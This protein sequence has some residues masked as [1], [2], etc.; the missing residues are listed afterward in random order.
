MGLTSNYGT[1][2]NNGNLLTV[3]YSGGGLSYTQT[4]DYDALN[5]LTTS[6]ESGAS[7]L[8]TNSYDRYGN[9]SI[10][11]GG[12]SFSASNNRITN[13]GYVYDAAGN[14]TNDGV[15]SYAFDAEN[16]V[17]TVN[18]E[19]DVY[20]YD[21]DGNRV[22]KNFTYGEK[23]RMVYS[24]QL[25]AE[26][27][28]STGS[29]K[30]EY[31][32]GAKGLI[33]TIEPSAGTRYT[34]SDHLGSPRV[35]SNSSAGVV[36]RHDYKPFGEELGAGEGGRT[37]AMGYDAAD[38]LRQKF[39][40]KERDN[41]TGL[42]YLLA[43]YYSSTQGRFTSADSFGGFM[44]NPQTLNRYAYVQN[45][46]L[47]FIDPTG[48]MAERWRI[49][50]LDYLFGPRVSEPMVGQDPKKKPLPPETQPGQDIGSKTA[51]EGGSPFGVIANLNIVSGQDLTPIET[52]NGGPTP[53]IQVRPTEVPVN[54][55]PSSAGYMDINVSW[56]YL[57][58]GPSVGVMFGNNGGISPYLGGG[59]MNP[60]PSANVS[61]SPDSISGGFNSEVQIGYGPATSW[62]WDETGTLFRSYGIGRGVSV[63]GYYVFNAPVPPR[64]RGRHWEHPNSATNSNSLRRDQRSRRNCACNAP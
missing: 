44:S 3:G 35:V 13:A 27:D 64:S 41:E 25:I 19:T 38:G 9:R 42:D 10:V 8:Q 60:G 36:S 37:T 22:R 58:V 40:S 57:I 1:I 47:N 29:L 21:G 7:W 5:R 45:D 55:P 14:L 32:Y 54:D 62:G 23:V 52:S 30:K 61:F 49:N 12:L 31:V 26:Y 53:S 2:N 63:T 39:T 15:H 11:G 33:A 6:V 28:L 24:G 48:H 20:R 4:F 43:R 50:P 59:A 56:G 17:K 34:T 16:K 18:S 51:E 46:P